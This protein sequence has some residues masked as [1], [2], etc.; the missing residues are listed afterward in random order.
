M[1]LFQIWVGSFHLRTEEIATTEI[2]FYQHT[3]HK[4]IKKNAVP[5]KYLWI[6]DF[7]ELKYEISSVKQ[8]YCKASIYTESKQGSSRNFKYNNFPLK[9]TE[10]NNRKQKK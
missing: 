9:K 8:E 6:Y 5:E 7:L 2:K 4:L 3:S 1:K 10:E